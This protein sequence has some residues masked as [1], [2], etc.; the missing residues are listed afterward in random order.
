[1]TPACA[2]APRWRTTVMPD[3]LDLDRLAPSVDTDRA[4]AAFHRRQRRSTAYRRG[5]LAAAAVSVLVAGTVAGL[6]LSD[7]GTPVRT[8]PSNASDPGEVT[9]DVLAVGEGSDTPM[10]TLRA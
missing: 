5:A 6:A 2:C 8:G 4:R 9:F 10:G 1:M 3:D 7:D